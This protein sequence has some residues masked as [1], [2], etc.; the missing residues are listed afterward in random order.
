MRL[1]L[2]GRLGRGRHSDAVIAK[3]GRMQIPGLGSVHVLLRRLRCDEPPNVVPRHVPLLC[4]V[5][6]DA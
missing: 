6:D 1:G 5:P 2:V 3:K 4:D